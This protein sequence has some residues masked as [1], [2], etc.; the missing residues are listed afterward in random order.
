MTEVISISVGMEMSV[1]YNLIS[2]RVRLFGPG[3]L[4]EETP[5]SKTDNGVHI[6]SSEEI[7]SMNTPGL[8]FTSATW[9]MTSGWSTNEL[10]SCLLFFSQTPEHSISKATNAPINVIPQK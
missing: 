3:T 8:G 10:N 9:V 6:T 5:S 7:S 1:A 2:F 4:V